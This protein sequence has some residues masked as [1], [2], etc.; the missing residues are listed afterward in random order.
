MA[1]AEIE[2]RVGSAPIRWERALWVDGFD[3][4]YESLASDEEVRL[5]DGEPTEQS[6]VPG[7]VRVVVVSEDL[8]QGRA[9]VQLPREVVMGGRRIW[10]SLDKLRR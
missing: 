3:R 8:E 10:V 4:S 9:L 7:L 5:L 1:I 6:T 2:V